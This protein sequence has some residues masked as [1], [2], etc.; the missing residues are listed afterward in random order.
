M[1]SYGPI[2][3]AVTNLTTSACM[4]G[5]TYLL[6]RKN[7]FISLNYSVIL[8]TICFIFICF[9][10]DK[11]IPNVIYAFGLKVFLFVIVGIIIVKLKFIAVSEMKMVIN[12]IT[13]PIFN[14]QNK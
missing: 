5:L 10:I 12:K 6:A 2:M 9:G 1:P 7:Y 14:K 3:A 11:F 13:G 8:G 4:F